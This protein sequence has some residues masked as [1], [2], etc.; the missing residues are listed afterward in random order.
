MTV[1]ELIMKLNDYKQDARVLIEDA[2]TSWLFQ[3]PDV[4]SEGQF[5][6]LYSP[7]AYG[8]SPTLHDLE[9]AEEKIK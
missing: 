7:N 6:I 4:K 1:A 2:D 8:N 5:V 3:D 9:E